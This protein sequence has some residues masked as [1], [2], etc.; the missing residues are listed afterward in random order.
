MVMVA[1]PWFLVILDIA[2]GFVSGEK[3]Q[4]RK[5]DPTLARREI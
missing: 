5:A 1:F 3:A 4:L 2:A